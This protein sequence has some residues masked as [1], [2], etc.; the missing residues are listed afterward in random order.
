MKIFNAILLPSLN[1]ASYKSPNH[2]DKWPVNSQ[3]VGKL[4]TTMVD[5]PEPIDLKASGRV[6]S[7]LNGSF[8][9][10][11][12]GKFEFGNRTFEHFFD[13]SAVAQRLQIK[14]GELSYR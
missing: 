5:H 9:R 8:Y 2:F 10:N 12:P 6:P 7:W 13:P 3:N 4:F 11:G 14:N 1:A